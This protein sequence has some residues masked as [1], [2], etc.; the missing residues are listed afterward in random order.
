MCAVIQIQYADNML[1]QDT[2][3]KDQVF[4]IVYF[5]SSIRNLTVHN[6]RQIQVTVNSK[7][8]GNTVTKTKGGSVGWPQAASASCDMCP[9]SFPLE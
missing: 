9:L 5:P 3:E 8:V 7:S 1:F 4:I 2:N 6:R